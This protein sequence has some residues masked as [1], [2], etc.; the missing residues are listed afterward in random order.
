MLIG[1]RNVRQVIG[2][3]GTDMIGHNFLSDDLLSWRIPEALPDKPHRNQCE[4]YNGGY[5]PQTK[6][7]VEPGYA[8]FPLFSPPLRSPLSSVGDL[9]KR[10]SRGPPVESWN[11]A[12]AYP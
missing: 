6:P 4:Q 7:R 12:R 8:L 9:A 2:H 11:E 5:W 10:G 3:E 1:G